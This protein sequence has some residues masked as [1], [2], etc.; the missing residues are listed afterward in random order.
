[1]GSRY[2]PSDS[3]PSHC[4]R[5][6]TLNGRRNLGSGRPPLIDA[7]TGRICTTDE[8]SGNVDALAA[9][10]HQD[11]GWERDENGTTS[12]VIGVLCVNSVSSRHSLLSVMPICHIRRT[13]RFKQTAEGSPRS[14]S[15]SCAGQSIALEGHACSCNLLRVYSRWFHTWRNLIVGRCLCARSF[16]R[17]VACFWPNSPNCRKGRTL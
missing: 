3:G 16:Q 15:S 8:V 10:L 2:H 17:S 1:M 12:K 11:L 7:P 4:G 14:N 5:L 13:R 9:A 6:H